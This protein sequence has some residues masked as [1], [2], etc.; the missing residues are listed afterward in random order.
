MIRVAAT[1]AQNT[2]DILFEKENLQL[3]V[4]PPSIFAFYI[5]L[6]WSSSASGLTL[7][8]FEHMQT[9]SQ[10]ERIIVTIKSDKNS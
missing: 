6:R 10:I 4:Q 3:H 8:R 9:T 1:V 5:F 7:L 2:V